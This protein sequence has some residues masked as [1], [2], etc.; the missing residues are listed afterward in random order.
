EDRADSEVVGGFDDIR[1]GGGAVGGEGKGPA[2]IA[3]GDLFEDEI[4]ADAVVG[5]ERGVGLT[6]ADSVIT[7][8][9]AGV[10][11]AGA[12]GQKRAGEHE[13][14]GAGEGALELRVDRFIVTRFIERDVNRDGGGMRGLDAFEAVGKG[15]ADAGG[16]AVLEDGLFVDR[17]NDGGGLPGVGRLKAEKEVVGVFVELLAE[18]GPAYGDAD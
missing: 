17:E 15:G 8:E 2:A 7:E 3:A 18:G 6:N 13:V 12:I 5:I 4:A 14:T 11:P 1:I 10:V 9:R 16:V